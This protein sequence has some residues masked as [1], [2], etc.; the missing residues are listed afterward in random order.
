MTKS[1]GVRANLRGW[2]TLVGASGGGM[3]CG[4]G[5]CSVSYGGSAIFQGDV[6][7]GLFLAF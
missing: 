4:G 6:S 5:G 2:I 3:F 1:I 7:G